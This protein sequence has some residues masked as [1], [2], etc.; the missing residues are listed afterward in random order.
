M[1]ALVANAALLA[2]DILA[3]RRR[4]LPV[5]IPVF[6][7]A[8]GLGGD[9]AGLWSP[10]GAMQVLAW[11]LFLHL[12]LVLLSRRRWLLAAAL[13]IVAVDAF[14]VEPRAVELSTT[15]VEGP[16]LRIALVT[17]IQTDDVGEYERHVLDLV[18]AAAPDLILFAGDY[19]QVSDPGEYRR[20][21]HLLATALGDLDATL[22]AFAV[23]GDVEPGDW[24]AV[25]AGTQVAR[26]DDTRTLELR[27][28]LH[29]TLLGVEDSM[30]RHARIPDTDGFHVVVGHRPDYA[31]GAPPADLLLAGHVHGGQVRLPGLGPLLT[32]SAVPRAWAVGLTDLPSGGQLYVSRGIG[33]ERLDAPRLRFWCRPELSII[34][35]GPGVLASAGG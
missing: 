1:V 16:P 24:S 35:V 4:W 5:A 9:L 29:L 11:G 3:W 33:M 7:A 20:Q 30:S 19:V 31:L 26:V 34:D 10:F 32:L 25:F 21:A 2:L 23:R 18:R 13:A 17:D 15:R 6:A 22:G 27:E 12:P 14:V 28:G 8:L